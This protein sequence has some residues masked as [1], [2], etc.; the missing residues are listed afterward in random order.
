MKNKNIITFSSDSNYMKYTINLL[1]SIKKNCNN[2]DVFYRGVNITDEDY[3]KILDYNIL[4]VIDKINL[5]TKKNLIKEQY[6]QIFVNNKLIVSQMLY[7]EAISYT[8]HSRFKNITYLLR[9]G[10][11]TILAL[12]ADTYVNKNIDALFKDYKNFDI[13]SVPGDTDDDKENFFLNEGLL[14]INRSQKVLDYFTEIESY[15][16]KDGHFKDWD[17][18]T[19]I[20][21]K[22]Q[23][24]YK[25]KLG[26]L[27]PSYKSRPNKNAYMWSGDGTNKHEK[28]IIR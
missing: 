14:L 28:S 2:I 16:F 7:S 9:E 24:K 20:L 10:Y 26:S 8:C 3:L 18:D 15:L 6:K 5:S 21:T 27:D 12:D 11:D 25:L 17:S 19:K 1:N 22:L 23:Y 13:C 4:H